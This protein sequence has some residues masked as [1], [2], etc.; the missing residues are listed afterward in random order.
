MADAEHLVLK[1]AEARAERH[2]EMFQHDSAK[3][4]AG[5]PGGHVKRRDRIAV[6]PRIEGNDLQTPGSRRTPR[7]FAM[8]PVTRE[9]VGETFLGEHLQGFVKAVEKI[10]GRSVWEESV[11]VLREYR[12]PIPVCFREPRRF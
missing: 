2:V 4:V 1:T 8:T 6:L 10:R 12:R 7:R 5:V 9:H 3:F 11:H